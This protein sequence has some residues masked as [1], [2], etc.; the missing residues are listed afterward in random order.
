M[1]FAVS[2]ISQ[3]YRGDLDWVSQTSIKP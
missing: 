2:T 3:E 1:K